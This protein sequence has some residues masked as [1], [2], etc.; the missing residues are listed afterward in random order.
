MK[1]ILLVD[2]LDIDL[3]FTRMALDALRLKWHF[4][5]AADGEDAMRRLQADS[6]SLVLLD[7]KMPKVTGF[8]LLQNMR[9]AGIKV[10][11]IIVSGSALIKD[12][13]RAA[14]LGAIDYVVKGVDFA[15]FREELESALHRSGFC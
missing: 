14:E 4:V 11:A 3:M 8:E 12:K 13:E 2:D 15:S 1:K 5:T 6:F 10:P 9:E 7:I